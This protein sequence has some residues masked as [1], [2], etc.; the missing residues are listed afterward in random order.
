MGDGCVAFGDMRLPPSHVHAGW[1]LQWEVAGRIL[2][3]SGSLGPLLGLRG[4]SSL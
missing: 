1:G 2:G 3:D 4:L